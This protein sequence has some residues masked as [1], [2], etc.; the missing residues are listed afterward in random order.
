MS[1]LLVVQND[2]VAPPG[3][4]V[5]ACRR[6]GVPFDLARPFTGEPVAPFA[7]RTGVVVLGGAM[8]VG[9]AAEYPFLLDEMS[10]ISAAADA[11]VA[12][13]GI[14]LG[15]Q[16]IAAAL[17]GA[18]MRADHPEAVVVEMSATD[19]GTDPVLGRLDGP[20]LALHQ[21]TW[22]APPDAVALIDGPEFPFAFRSGSAV[23]IQTHP[24]VT[25][26]IFRRWVSI[27]AV[28]GLVAHAGSDPDEL[29][30]AFEA[31]QPRSRDMA[32]RF[33]GAWLDE[34]VERREHRA[35]S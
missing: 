28:R 25:V 14:C 13:L 3:H 15:G 32:M 35:V 10:E 26:D 6:A 27:P 34:A 29:M 20:Q 12:V 11:G 9:D 1:T 24:E 7:D 2:A 5:D 19:V 16:L 22:E 33:F 21:D 8:G 30:S 31:A 17:G 23:A 18:V 4:L